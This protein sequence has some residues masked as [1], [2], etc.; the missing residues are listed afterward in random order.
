MA[1]PIVSG[2]AGMLYE[3]FPNISAEQVQQA[4][5]Q[6]ENKKD[7]EK[8]KGVDAKKAIENAAKLTGT[9]Y[10]EKEKVIITGNIAI[11]KN[12]TNILNKYYSKIKVNIYNSENRTDPIATSD[13]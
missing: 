1:T 11:N 12:N 10:E 4:I 5:L 3:L 13:I 6:S 2:I 7:N 8:N 9:P